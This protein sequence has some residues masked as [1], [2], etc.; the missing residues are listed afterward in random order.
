MNSFH[1]I[2]SYFNSITAKAFYA[3]NEML[4]SL[5][6]LI[7]RTQK[8]FAPYAQ[9]ALSHIIDVIN[10][11]LTKLSWE[12]KKYILEI[13]YNIILF[14][15]EETNVYIDEIISFAKICKVDKVKEEL[16]NNQ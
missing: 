13:V 12:N 4:R 10:H 7:I 14:C 11:S 2:I 8:R 15:P 1:I 6:I 3:K 5:L 9:D 16:Y